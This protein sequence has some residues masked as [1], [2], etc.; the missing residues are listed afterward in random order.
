MKERNFNFSK[1]V[2]SGQ[3][4]TKR[5]II[6]SLQAFAREKKAE[7]FTQ[8]EYDRWPRRVL[9]S[10]QIAVRFSGWHKAM[11][12]AGLSPQWT[13][14]KNPT[15]MVETFM[16]CWEEH[17]DC[18][19]DNAFS[20]HLKKNDSK[21]TIN[22][23]KRYFGGLRRL[24][25]RVIDF[26]GKRISEKQLLER[27]ESPRKSRA[28]VPSAIRYQ[29]INRDEHKCLI[30]GKGAADGVKLEIDHI[31]HA[32]KGGTNELTNLRTLCD[33]CNRGRGDKD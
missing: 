9:C 16:D 27:W 8:K 17:D 7:K 2:H 1:Y 31:I 23:Y 32:S 19:T 18:P 24:S 14:T 5:E 21:Y 20:A 29:V 6:E 30:C 25:A 3:K 28:P 15:E 22:H 4:T 11:E 10:S 12:A 26:H 13:F 33:I